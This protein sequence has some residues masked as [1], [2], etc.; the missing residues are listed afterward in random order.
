MKLAVYRSIDLQWPIRRGQHLLLRRDLVR[1]ECPLL[2]T[3]RRC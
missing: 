3:S 2:V 1:E